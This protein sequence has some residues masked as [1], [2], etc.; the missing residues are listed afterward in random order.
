MRNKI[1]F[2]LLSYNWT[3]GYNLYFGANQRLDLRFQHWIMCTGQQ[4]SVD[5]CIFAQYF[6]DVFGYKLS[7]GRMLILLIFYQ[8][9]QHWTGVLKSFYMGGKLSQLNWKRI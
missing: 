8:R 1:A 5:V 9:H 7:A 6:L 2:E 4:Q 3:L